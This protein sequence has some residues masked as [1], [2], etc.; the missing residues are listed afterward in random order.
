MGS[1]PPP[2]NQIC[3]F[4]I[5]RFCEPV[6]WSAAGLPAQAL[7]CEMVDFVCFEVA[8]WNGGYKIEKEKKKQK[9]RG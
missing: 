9:R 6:L 1:Q 7:L 5:R 4:R 8:F 2:R 3:P